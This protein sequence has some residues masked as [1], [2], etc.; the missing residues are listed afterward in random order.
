MP[1]LNEIYLMGNL[2]RDPESRYTPGGYAVCTLS[3]AINRVTKD[4]DGQRKEEVT[5]VDVTCWGKTAENAAKYLAKGRPVFIK[6]RLKLDAWEDKQTGQQRSALKVVAESMQLL[7]ERPSNGGDSPPARQ[8]APAARTPA[9]P[10]DP[11]L[12]A[13][14]E[15]DDIPF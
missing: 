11:D 1:N 13:S 3:L 10:R 9:R 12:D 8:P 4:R 7:G 5:Y 6:G 15:P 14:P 2:T